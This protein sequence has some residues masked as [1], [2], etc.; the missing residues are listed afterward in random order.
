MVGGKRNSISFIRKQS[1]SYP[2]RNCV[3]EIIGL[4]SAYCGRYN[5]RRSTLSTVLPKLAVGRKTSTAVQ[6]GTRRCSEPFLFD[7]INGQEKWSR[8]Q[9]VN[10]SHGKRRLSTA[11]ILPA[12]S[13]QKLQAL[14]NDELLASLNV[15][16]TAKTDTSVVDDQEDV[17]ELIDTESEIDDS[18]EKKAQVEKERRE[19]KRLLIIEEI[20]ETEKNYISCLETLNAVFRSQL[21]DANI[22]TEKD[23]NSL[24]PSHLQDIKESHTHFMTGLE[25]RMNNDDWR[26]I[27]GD[28]F[29]KMTSAPV[30]LLEMYTA[31][32]NSFPKAISTLSKC[33]RSS[34]KFRKFLEDCYENP[35]V[36]RLDLPSFLLSPVQR[37]P[38][39]ILLLRELLKYT[40]EDHP[41][42]FF[43]T[44]AMSQM[45]SLI[46]SLNSS[47]HKSMEFYSAS[48]SRRKKM[49]R[50]MTSKKSKH[51]NSSAILRSNK[52]LRSVIENKSDND[53]GYCSFGERKDES[54]EDDTNVG[55]KARSS[56]WR[57]NSKRSMSMVSN[58]SDDS[59]KPVMRRKQEIMLGRN[60]DTRKSWRRSIGAVFSHLWSANRDGEEF[61]QISSKEDVSMETNESLD[62]S[63]LNN[64]GSQD[65][66]D[67]IQ[68]INSTPT[69]RKSS[70]AKRKVAITH[71][72]PSPTIEEVEMLSPTV[73]VLDGNENIQQ[74][75][76]L[77]KN[78]SINDDESTQPASAPL[79]TG[80]TE[81]SS[82][83][84]SD[85]ERKN[86]TQS[87]L[88]NTSSM[89]KISSSPQHLRR[90]GKLRGSAGPV[91]KSIFQK[92]NQIQKTLSVD[93][94][95]EKF[96]QDEKKKRSL[97]KRRK[98]SHL[99]MSAT[100]ITQSHLAEDSYGMVK[101]LSSYTISH[102][103]DNHLISSTET[104]SSKTSGSVKGDEGDYVITEN[105]L[106]SFKQKNRIERK[107]KIFKTLK[108]FVGKK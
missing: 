46:S 37:L 33:T 56:T 69:R 41:D 8:K 6:K 4:P 58:A 104:I 55:R 34:N 32:V 107:S 102:E 66:L 28:I 99:H 93:A 62:L 17:D 54:P 100:A 27:I 101:S 39:Y 2:A 63:E 12:S 53:Q 45:E 9:S 70:S 13:K 106:S 92:N 89:L 75:N 77:V 44:E 97:K 1:K 40:D 81:V 76:T 59:S 61:P 95:N 57:M 86:S 47:I 50:Q 103:K 25:E 90:G 94:L 83:I 42:R 60:V 48:N 22:I 87:E 21:K 19:T 51:R 29:A 80:E 68:P 16:L 18:D 7:S 67:G 20:L 52:N 73:E 31:Y 78:A 65:N 74:I 82:C 64:P 23:L 96:T 26:G 105:N 3:S 14:A 108:S 10:K 15:P 84:T 38:R 35:V 30:N 88:S 5:F 79:S 36:E 24:F 72:L 91:L 11:G 43:I 71:S 98:D 49:S 85:D